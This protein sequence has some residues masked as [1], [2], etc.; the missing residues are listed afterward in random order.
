M[1]PAVGENVKLVS[2]SHVLIQVAAE[3]LFLVV[4]LARQV[5]IRGSSLVVPWVLRKYPTWI[6]I[7]LFA[8]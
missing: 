5:D 4:T 7:G 1:A 3:Q 2:W 6:N 8:Y